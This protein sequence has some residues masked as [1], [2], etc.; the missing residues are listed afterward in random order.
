MATIMKQCKVAG[1]A[2]I[3]SMIPS[4][5]ATGGENWMTDYD[6]ARAK[7]LAEK[8]QISGFPTIVLLTPDGELIGKTGYRPGGA[9]AYV[10]HLKKLLAAG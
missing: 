10:A 3:L 6:A 2:V 1:L 9:K 5:T 7:A 8:F 4:I